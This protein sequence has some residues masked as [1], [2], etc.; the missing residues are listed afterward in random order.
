MKAEG[1][2]WVEITLETDFDRV[3]H[4]GRIRM[5]EVALS[6]EEEAHLSAL[7]ERYDELVAAIEEE[8]DDETSA[9]LD[10]VSAELNALRAKKEVWPEEERGRA[11]VV[12]S[13]DYDGKLQIT[14]GLVKP[15]ERQ[16]DEND[17]PRST[18]VTAKKEKS[19]N[20]YAES[21]LI[22]LSAHRTAA[23]R[24]VLAG[25]PECAFTALLH[26]LV[27][28]IFF[29][30]DGRGCIEIMPTVAELG[31][32]SQTVGESKAAA[33][34][35]VRHNRWLELLPERTEVWGWL[36]RMEHS[37]RLELLAYCTA[38]TVDAVYR[39]ERDQGR[40]AQAD[41]L[42]HAL[43]LDM[44]DWWRPTS[45][46][47]FDRITKD[48]IIRAVSEGVSR[49]AAHPLADRKKSHMGRDAEVLLANRRWVPE[50]LRT[51][52]KD[53]EPTTEA[54]ASVVDE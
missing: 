11:G 54:L 48:Q 14:R 47:F 46:G 26:A 51:F 4:F 25:Q 41:L 38:L 43:S 49:E 32:L 52:K 1:W 10:R 7:C 31:K 33:A 17:S 28:R 34:L 30:R 23:L 20:G 44:A 15:E 40:S 16:R 36:D 50:P 6:D 18:N 13:L 8:G 5:V 19:S 37:L 27:L 12:I 39:R 53:G 29:N 45:A 2:A 35:L 24:E 42:A 9:E 3:A 21:L 22:D